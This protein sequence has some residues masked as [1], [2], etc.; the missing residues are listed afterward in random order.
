MAN[1]ESARAQGVALARAA[2]LNEP[3]DWA[4]DLET[5]KA[6]QR[7]AAEELAAASAAKDPRLIA[8]L[9][10]ADERRVRYEAAV[11]AKARIDAAVALAESRRPA[12]PPPNI[13]DRKI[14]LAAEIE[15]AKTAEQAAMRARAAIEQARA[16]QRAAQSRLDIAT[17]SRDRAHA[18]FVEAAELAAKSGKHAP[19]NTVRPLEDAIV[20]CRAALDA[21]HA[22]VASC[23]TALADPERDLARAKRRVAKAADDFIRASPITAFVRETRALKEQVIARCVALR[24]LF[25]ENLLDPSDKEM[26]AMFLRR[27]TLPSLPGDVELEDWSKHSGADP[28]RKWREALTRD[29]DAKPPL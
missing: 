13:G 7:R 28:F 6:E 18:E 25:S 23:E 5:A 10:K 16:N 24:Y 2:T 11:E 19:Q 29:A 21:A 4:R 1:I 20:D 27:R 26:V 14:A 9:P 17:A 15:S 12:P 22:A 8:L 3:P